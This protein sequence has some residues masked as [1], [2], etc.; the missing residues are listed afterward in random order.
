MITLV[1]VQRKFW[2]IYFIFQKNVS[3]L[4]PVH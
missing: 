4:I 3:S 1:E 2:C